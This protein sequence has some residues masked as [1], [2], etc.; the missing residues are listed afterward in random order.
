M[1]EFNYDVTQSYENNFSNWREM[2][3]REK[4]EHGEK[5]YPLEEGRKIFDDMYAKKY[6]SLI[7]KLLRHG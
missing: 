7:G 3:S 6:K 1:E 4:R 2:N 5:E